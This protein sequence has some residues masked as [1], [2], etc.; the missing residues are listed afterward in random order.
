MQDVFTPFCTLVLSAGKNIFFG[1]TMSKKDYDYVV[2]MMK[3]Y[4]SDDGIKKRCIIDYDA[5]AEGLCIATRSERKPVSFEVKAQFRR[6]YER[7]VSRRLSEIKEPLAIIMFQGIYNPIIPRNRPR[8][9]MVYI[10]DNLRQ[11]LRNLPKL[12]NG[13]K[14]AFPALKILR[15]EDGSDAFIFPR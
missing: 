2:E 6:A 11:V 5:I 9:G 15:E 7:Y 4:H 12:P 8:N 13:E 3:E 14:Y 10:E 1:G